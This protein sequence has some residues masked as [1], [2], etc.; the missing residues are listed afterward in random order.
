MGVFDKLKFFETIGYTPHQG[1]LKLHTSK[2]RF[3]ILAC[4]ARWGKST[5][6]M[7][8]A[9]AAMVK[10]DSMGWVVGCTYDMADIIFGPLIREWLTIRPDFVES[11]SFSKRYIMLKNGAQ[12]W[13]RSAEKPVSLLGRGLD[14]EVVDEP[15]NMKEI[16]WQ[17]YL[18]SRLMERKGWAMFTS[19]P[20]GKGWYW[21]LFKKG[22]KKNE[23]MYDSDYHS[24]EGPSW[25]NPI[26]DKEF[27]IRSKK[28]YT[29]RYWKQEVLGEFLDDSGTVFKHVRRYATGSLAEP[30]EGMGYSIGVDL[31]KSQDWTVI[32]VMNPDGCVVYWERIAQGTNWDVQRMRVAEASKKYNNATCYVDS[33]GLGD[34]VVDEMMAVGVPVYPVK[35]AQEKPMLVEALVIAME[36]GKIC[37]PDL[38]ILINELEIFEHGKTGIAKRDT[39]NA[40]EGFHDD[41]VISLALAWRGHGSVEGWAIPTKGL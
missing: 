41:A 13:A 4:G 3:R 32:T 36:N 19:T 8:E 40:P 22:Q 33:S 27:V 35:T 23:S 34:P 14:W 1:Q 29:E 31:G 11:Y 28:N 15:G 38:P 5:A 7:Y 25:Q 39:Y 6:A 30:I 9:M 18:Q 24:Q 12:A 16:V 10:P 37:Y 17:E 2:A 26:V 20:K 21:H